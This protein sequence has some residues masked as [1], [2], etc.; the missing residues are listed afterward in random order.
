MAFLK[1]PM[2]KELGLGF[3]PGCDILVEVDVRLRN[4]AGD[5]VDG[6]S[7]KLFQYSPPFFL[8]IKELCAHYIPEN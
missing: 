1:P 8:K 4:V 5:A 6:F 7:A 2:K 3:A